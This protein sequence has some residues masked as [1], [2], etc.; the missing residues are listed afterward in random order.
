[1]YSG[2]YKYDNGPN[3]NMLNRRTVGRSC[4]EEEFR[5]LR[6][7]ELFREPMTKSAAPINSLSDSGYILLGNYA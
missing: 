1:M 2:F 5:E 7:R 3:K 4:S 6:L